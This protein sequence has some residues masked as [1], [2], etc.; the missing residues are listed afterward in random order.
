LPAHEPPADELPADELPSDALPADLD[1]TRFVGPTVFPDV[2]RRRIAGAIYLLGAVAC[3]VGALAVG[4]G[5][6]PA[7]AALAAAGT[8]HLLAGWP[9]RVDETQALVI[10]T[11]A[12]GFPIGHASAQ[13]AWYGWRSRPVWRVLCYSADDPPRRRGLVELD[14]LEGHVMGSYDEPNPEDWSAFAAGTAGEAAPG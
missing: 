3:A 8:Y 12:I 9:L 2:A 7:A 4:Y 5:L 13:L 10:A 1:V 6:G 14:G 11:R